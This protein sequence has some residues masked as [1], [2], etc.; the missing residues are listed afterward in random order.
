MTALAPVVCALDPAPETEPALVAAVEL[1]AR[2][3]GTL[4]LMTVRPPLADDEYRA[5]GDPEAGVRAVVEVTVD[6]ALGA[7]AYAEIAPRI[8]VAREDD[9]AASV[10]QY[11][12]EVG[13]GT[14]VLGTHG[15]VGLRRFRLGSV[16]EAVV[17]RAPCPVLVVPNRSTGR[18]PGPDR[19]VLVPVD[20]S[21]PSARA[22]ALARPLADLYGAPV[23]VLHVEDGLGWAALAAT[24]LAAHEVGVPPN[25]PP[26]DADLRAFAERVGA[27]DVGAHVATGSPADA[28]VARA[29]A[30]DAGAVVMGTHGRSGPARALFGSV[31]E[32]ALRRLRCPLLTVRPAAP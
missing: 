10:A 23:E 7:G 15:R 9:P 31:T 19:P 16:A 13:V 8:V 3:G 22:L 26:T 25:S 27:G 4:H 20:F 5:P 24:A 17:R 12:G 21:E 6:R 1:A 29:E 28:V 11:A 2:M 18:T 14:L 32:A 30:L